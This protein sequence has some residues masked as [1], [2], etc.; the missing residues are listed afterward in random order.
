MSGSWKCQ[1]KVRRIHE[2]L[3]D[4]MRDN[5]ACESCVQ[6]LSLVCS[7]VGASSYCS[8]I[9]RRLSTASRV[10]HPQIAIGLYPGSGRGS[11]D[12]FAGSSH[13]R[14]T[15]KRRGRAQ[16]RPPSKQHRLNGM[17]NGRLSSSRGYVSGDLVNG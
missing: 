4:R 8:I 15:G 6:R 17:L 7:D 1:D 13:S 16:G 10:T 14:H 5:V 3:L 9:S 12:G 2:V 11:S